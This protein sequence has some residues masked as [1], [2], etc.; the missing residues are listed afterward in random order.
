M[1]NGIRR[2]KLR[3]DNG[4]SGMSHSTAKI[5]I[6]R[7]FGDDKNSPVYS[8]EL[9]TSIRKETGI[10]EYWTGIARV[11]V[12]QSYFRV[13]DCIIQ[14]LKDAVSTPLN[15]SRLED[16]IVALVGLGYELEY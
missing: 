15:K 14:E 11:N 7:S 3:L 8:F 5:T 10:C 6:T 9:E 1:S 16:I 13:L 4:D 2:M 12:Y